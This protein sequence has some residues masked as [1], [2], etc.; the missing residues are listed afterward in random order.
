MAVYPEQFRNRP[1]GWAVRHFSCLICCQLELCGG[2]SASSMAASGP[3]SLTRGPEYWS[4]D[5]YDND[6]VYIDYSG[7]GYHLY[8]RSYPGDRIAVGGYLR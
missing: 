6:D 2:N 4:D 3:V 8:N 7:D 5:W 1:L